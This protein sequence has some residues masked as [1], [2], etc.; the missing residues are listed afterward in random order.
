MARAGG[1]F[2]GI[3][4]NPFYKRRQNEQK[5]TARNADG[6]C[7][8]KAKPAPEN[9]DGI[10]RPAGCLPRGK[11]PPRNNDNGAGRLSDGWLTSANSKSLPK[12]C[13][14]PAAKIPE[15]AAHC[16]SLDAF[17]LRGKNRNLGVLL[18]ASVGATPVYFEFAYREDYRSWKKVLAVLPKPDMVV[19]DGNTGLCRALAELWADVPRQRCLNHISYETGQ[20]LHSCLNTEAGRELNALREEI[21][22][23]ATIAQAHDWEL[24]FKDWEERNR[25]ALGQREEVIRHGRRYLGRYT[26][27]ALRAGYAHLKKA[28][29]FMFVYLHHKN[30]QRTTSALEGGIN[31]PLRDIPRRHRGMPLARLKAAIAH[32]LLFKC[33]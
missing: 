30:G 17:W 14:L 29:P 33:G 16:L 19:A 22:L 21:L 5:N 18:I 12:S 3:I 9:N 10:A 15:T 6:K 28:L 11:T 24:R 7:T 1:A 25:E 27:K 20:K 2:W 8:T 4:Y 13:A 31:A 23:V 26:N 32:F